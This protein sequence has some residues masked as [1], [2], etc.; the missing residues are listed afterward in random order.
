VIL[1]YIFAPIAKLANAQGAYKS[2]LCGHRAS[3]DQRFLS[4][5]SSNDFIGV[6]IWCYMDKFIALDSAI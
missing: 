6:G 2:V 1:S 3:G 4:F 5:G